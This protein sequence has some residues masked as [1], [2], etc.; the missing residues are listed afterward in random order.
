MS[1]YQL[2]SNKPLGKD[3]GALAIIKKNS[4]VLKCTSYSKTVSFKI[5][6]FCV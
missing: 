4:S 5:I 1:A 6:F 3:I 2:V